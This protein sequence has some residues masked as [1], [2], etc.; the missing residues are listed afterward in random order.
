MPILKLIISCKNALTLKYGAA[1]FKKVDALLAKLA[2]ADKKKG[3]TTKV[4]Y[5]DD[6]ASAS[7]AGIP[8]FASTTEKDCKNAVDALYTKS[9]PDYILLFGAQDIVPFVS[10]VNPAAAGEDPD[11]TVPSDLPYACD[12][13]YS[14]Q[15]QDFI[16]PTRVVG[17][18]PDI[19]GKGDVAYVQALVDTASGWKPGKAADYSAY[20][21]ITAK[22]WQK[23]TS[24]SLQSVFGNFSAL[25]QCPSDTATS[26]S[27]N[28][29]PLS[30]FINCHGAALDY[31]FYGQMGMS[32][33]ES[34]NTK[35]LTGK[36]GKGAVVAA[37]CCY[38]AQLINATNAGG[39]TQLSISNNYLL[40]GALGFLGSSTIAYGPADSND[41]ADLVCVYFFQSVLKGASMGRSLLEAR[42]QYLSKAG[43]HL[44]P[45]ALKTMSQF[46][47]LGDPSVQPVENPM[48]NKKAAAGADT[49]KGR[50]LQLFNKGAVLQH[51]TIPCKKVPVKKSVRR[52][53]DIRTILEQEGMMASKEEH[54]IAD[55]KRQRASLAAKQMAGGPIQFRTFTLAT[56]E[57]GKKRVRQIKLLLVKESDSGILDY[58]VYFA[59]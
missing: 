4:V 49:I 36:I 10:I 32:Y 44:D 55:P 7:K 42:Q 25:L 59:R 2:A 37:E 3:I 21:G 31:S 18:L 28:L 1:D 39:G 16:G 13:P 8:V 6:P 33:P 43:P 17:R 24:L 56:P 27:G 9:K 19:P 30:H 26:K 20:F 15:A 54:Y 57:K 34:M 47:L 35:D 29:K 11:T 45:V 23:S 40:N 51:S 58:H 53:K 50:R 5:I 52:R 12:A 48:D 14:T 38:G 22:V 46:Y 41:Q